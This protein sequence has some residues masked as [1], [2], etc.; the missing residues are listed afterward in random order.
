MGDRCAAQTQVQVPGIPA[1]RK[2][3]SCEVVLLLGFFGDCPNET[4][5][6]AVSVL[7]RGG[8]FSRSGSR[9]SRL[10]KCRMYPV[11]QRRAN[12]PRGKEGRLPN[13]ERSPPAVDDSPAPGRAARGCRGANSAGNDSA[14]KKQKSS[15]GKRNA[16]NVTQKRLKN[17]TLFLLATH[18]F[19]LISKLECKTPR[20]D[21][22]S[23][24]VRGNVAGL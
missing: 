11:A 10:S 3:R 9:C 5:R 18:F 15:Q 12:L 4:T 14:T 22:L 16:K 7:P 2:A 17:V 21:C 24:P 20:G 1:P 6:A 19:Q 13:D 8:R 23:S